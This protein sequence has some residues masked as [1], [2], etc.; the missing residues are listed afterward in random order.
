MGC[1][2]WNS[3]AKAHPG[4]RWEALSREAD[5]W[6]DLI[7]DEIGKPRV[8]A[9]AGDVVSTLDGI[10]WTVKH[11]GRGPREPEASAPGWQRLAADAGGPARAGARWAWSG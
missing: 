6:A 4:R 11:G 8:E 2:P 9:M 3:R 7:R 1:A 5:V 10:R